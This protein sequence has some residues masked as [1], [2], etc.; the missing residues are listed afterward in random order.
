MEKSRSELFELVWSKPMTHLAKELGLSDVGLRKICVKYGIPLP[1]RGYWARLQVGKQD[2]RPELPFENN[3]PQIRL[4]DEAT[5]VTR[6]QLSLMR[7]L[8]KKAEQEVEP[9]LREPQQ[10]KDIR[11]IRTYQ[12]ILERIKHLEKRTGQSYEDYKAGRRSFPPKKVY[13]LAFFY[14]LEDQIPI[15]ATIDNALRAVAIAD[16]VIERLALR[17]IEVEL[18]AVRDSRICEMRAVKG[19]QYLEFRFWEPSTKATRSSALTSLE[20]MFTDY[21][22]GGDSIMLPRHILTI[23][24]GGS[25]VT[26]LIQDKVSVKLE[27]QIDRVVEKIEQKLDQKAKAH[28]EHLAWERDYE[29]K[30]AIREHNERVIEDREQQLERAIAESLDYE[31]SQQLK[32]YLKQLSLAIDRLPEEPRAYGLAWLRMVREQ[33]KGLNPIAERLESFRILASE[34]AGDSEEYWGMDLIDEDHDPDFDEALEDDRL[35]FGW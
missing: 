33:R 26:S 10:F 7:K 5:A 16:V 3:N 31:K 25:Y 9:V 29:R 20:R 21:C 27:Q 6:E 35:T 28:L 17:G 22:Y 2:P 23:Q 1:A 8:A 19:E 30:K 24:F 12:A 13:D 4:P 34:Q 14:S 32:R 15:S 11:C 18:R